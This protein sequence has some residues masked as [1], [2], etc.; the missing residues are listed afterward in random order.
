MRVFKL[1]KIETSK[2]ISLTVAPQNN[3]RPTKKIDKAEYAAH[4][5]NN[6]TASEA[7]IRDALKK[8]GFNFQ[9]QAVVGGYIPDFYFPDQNKIVELDGR[10]FH[11]PVKDRK[12]DADLARLGITTFR[13]KSSRVFTAFRQVMRSIDLFVKNKPKTKRKRKTRTKPKATPAWAKVPR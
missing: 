2:A 5:R 3:L 9:F 10:Q 8:R 4:L 1:K 6:P 13:I 7:I 11:D 12:R